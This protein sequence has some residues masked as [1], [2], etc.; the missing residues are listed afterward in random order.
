[1]TARKELYD[2]FVGQVLLM[3][4]GDY[5]TIL[6]KKFVYIVMSESS[7][8][9]GSVIPLKLRSIRAVAKAIK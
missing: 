1:M 2:A 4:N 6:G 9:Y 3:P 8:K 5:I 7:V